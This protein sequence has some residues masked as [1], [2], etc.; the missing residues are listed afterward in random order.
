MAISGKKPENPD[1]ITRTK[2]KRCN[3]AVLQGRKNAKKSK[4]LLSSIKYNL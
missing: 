3:Y 1:I 4:L 2:Q